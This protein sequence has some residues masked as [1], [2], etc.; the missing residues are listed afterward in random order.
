MSCFR[1]SWDSCRAPTTVFVRA[2]HAAW[3]PQSSTL[4]PSEDLETLQRWTA[5]RKTSRHIGLAF[6]H[7]LAQPERTS[8]CQVAIDLGVTSDTVGKWR[9]R[10]I[11]KGIG[12]GIHSSGCGWIEHPSDQVSQQVSPSI[13]RGE[14]ER[15]GV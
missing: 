11:A 1:K 14:R 6:P 7:H 5:R 10:Y 9:K 3:P 2:S 12:S 15:L 8:N 13:E 4:G